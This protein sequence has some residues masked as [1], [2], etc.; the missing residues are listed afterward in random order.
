MYDNNIA[1]LLTTIGFTAK[2]EHPV[3]VPLIGMSK[4]TYTSISIGMNFRWKDML[5]MGGEVIVTSTK[6]CLSFYRWLGKHVSERMFCAKAVLHT[7]DLC[8]GAKGAPLIV[9]RVLIGILSYSEEC[10]TDHFPATFTKIERFVRWMIKIM[11]A[12]ETPPLESKE[13]DYD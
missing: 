3:N 11:K 7:P 9:D 2:N 1:L 6:E 10:S 8:N 4:A 12:H 13:V 5:L